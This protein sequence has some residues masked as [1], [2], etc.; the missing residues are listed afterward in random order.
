MTNLRI[1]RKTKRPRQ[2]PK[3]SRYYART[4]YRNYT[5][6]K[7]GPKWAALR[8]VF[9]CAAEATSAPREANFEADSFQIGVDNH[10]TAC[11][12]P[13]V[14]DLIGKRL[15]VQVRVKGI[16][17]KAI[18]A[19]RGTARW[20]IRD[21][22]GVVHQLLIP[23]TYCVPKIPIRLLSPQH[24]AQVMKS[25]EHTRDGTVCHTYSDRVVLMWDDRK[26][27]K[28]IRLGTS[29]VPT[30][31]S[32][33]ADKKYM[34][35]AK[36]TKDIEKEPVAYDAHWIPPDDEP[37]EDNDMTNP[38]M[39]RKMANKINQQPLSPATVI[40]WQETHNINATDDDVRLPDNVSPSQE[41]LVW[42]YR[43]GHMP[44]AR[45]REL[46]KVGLLPK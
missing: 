43:L 44:F 20:H 19:F 17:G 16:S 41:L 24:L 6:T 25:H 11:M 46:T 28:T 38:I 12:T 27:S 34:Q 42:H 45:L 4:K 5:R 8:Q 21:D 29:N 26:Y 23:N 33:S 9:G 32:A 40:D 37:G 31:W 35:F 14:H 3:C 18:A 39:T 10:A 7:A 13:N 2:K 36:H 30:M 15:K 1:P 22:Q